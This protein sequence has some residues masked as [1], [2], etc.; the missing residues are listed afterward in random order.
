[1]LG[2]NDLTEMPLASAIV[3][4]FIGLG[5]AF[6]GRKVVKILVFA[7]A[8]LAGASIAYTLLQNV[9]QPIPL[10]AAIV[11]FLVLGFLS[12]AIL[13]FIFGVMLGIVGYF[14]VVSLT[15]NQIMGIL[16]GIVI[17]VIGLFLFKYY[18]SIATAFGGGVLVFA[19]L[20][21]VGLPAVVSMLVG[22]IVGLVGA[23]VQFKQLHN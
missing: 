13:K 11:G 20:E 12:L 18:L 5:L 22:A 1:M 8:G 7:G 2:V 17:F 10:I 15:N 6:L 14:I 3:A 19:G 21:S 23:Y 9:A 4:I 16:A